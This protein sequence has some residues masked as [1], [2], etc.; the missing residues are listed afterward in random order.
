MAK[1][2]KKRKNLI[3][4][5]LNST[6]ESQASNKLDL[7]N[8]VNFD[9]SANTMSTYDVVSDNEIVIEDIPDQLVELQNQIEEANA[10]YLD[11]AKDFDIKVEENTHI[12]A[13]ND[14]L[15]KLI[16]EL[17]FEIKKLTDV[18]Y[19]KDNEISELEL[20]NIALEISKTN[21]ITQTNNQ[22]NNV[23]IPQNKYNINKPTR[24]IRIDQAK[25]EGYDSWN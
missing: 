19:R 9:D 23:T 4:D 20:K 18:V 5:L 7:S 22:K 21:E 17:N 15:T 8:N 24:N 6:I 12:K 2:T 14:R 10:R 3:S 11:L 25:L 13:E 16:N 1:T